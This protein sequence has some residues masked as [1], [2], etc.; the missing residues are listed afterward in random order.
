MA[1]DLLAYDELK[2]RIERA[3]EVSYRVLALAPDG[4]IAE[5]EFC[6]PFSEIELDNFVLRI[7]RA[8]GR[9]RAY[10]S[11]QMEEAKHLGSKLFDALIQGDVRDVYQAARRVSE[12]NERGLRVTLYLTGV[13]ELMGVPWEFLYERPSFLSQSVYTPLVRSL[14]LKTVRAPRKLTLP[15]QVLVLASQPI[16][17]DDLDIEQERGKLA[18]AL[19]VPS[20]KGLVEFRWLNRATLR[21]L[22]RAISAPDDIHVLHYIGHGGFDERSGSGVL[23]LEDPHG[24]PHEVTGE[25]FGSLLYDERSLRLA[26]LNSCE[27]ARTSHVDPFSGVA[28]SLVERGLPAVVGMQFEISDDAAITFAERLYTAVAQGLPV[29]T[30]LAHARK[31]VF[32]AGN[33]VEFGTPVL[34]LRAGDARLFEVDMP[35]ERDPDEPTERADFSIQIEYLPADALPGEEITWQLWIENTGQCRLSEVTVV[36]DDGRTVGAPTTLQPGSR[37]LARWKETLEPMASRLLTVTACDEIGSRISE[38]VAIRT[39]DVEHHTSPP[40]T[41][42]ERRPQ[43]SAGRAEFSAT[44]AS[45][46][47]KPETAALTIDEIVMLAGKQYK[48]QASRVVEALLIGERA[49]KWAG[50]SRPGFTG[51]EGL[52][53]ATGRRL[54]FVTANGNETWDYEHISDVQLIRRAMISPIEIKLFNGAR[55]ELSGLFEKLRLTEL[56]KFVR[57]L[58]GADKGRLAEPALPAASEHWTATPMQIAKKMRSLRVELST[59]THVITFNSSG[60]YQL[61]VNEQTADMV[62]FEADFLPTYELTLSD[63]EEIYPARVVVDVGGIGSSRVKCMSLNVAG[64]ALYLG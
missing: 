36:H 11:P 4:G 59:D 62:D 56:V 10:K 63:G 8:R 58:V 24:A 41:V 54:I 21:E 45:P 31:A 15:L 7:G 6:V 22:D 40:T 52:L 17:Y 25:E 33:D 64:R 9:T 28:T 16:G 38:Q 26:V 42:H 2:L 35:S 23:I 1:D 50:V 51:E 19:R 44:T 34:F 18:A 32:A 47:L 57:P 13:P 46:Y 3:D 49:Y 27:G 43:T 53:M 61:Q 55:V 37:H 39:P 5:G 12:V 60:K 48:K 14:D 20:S 29:D 30:A